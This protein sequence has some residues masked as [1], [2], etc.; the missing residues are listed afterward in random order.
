L[1]PP[2]LFGPEKK[3]NKT[4]TIPVKKRCVDGDE[5]FSLFLCPLYICCSSILLHT[6]V[7]YNWR[8]IRYPH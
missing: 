3:D 4:N 8:R 5:T 1:V 7:G 2:S 6:H